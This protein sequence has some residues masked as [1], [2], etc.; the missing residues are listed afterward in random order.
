MMILILFRGS[1]WFVEVLVGV[2]GLLLDVCLGTPSSNYYAYSRIFNLCVG[3]LTVGCEFVGFP[4]DDAS[5]WCIGFVNLSFGKRLLLL[6][7]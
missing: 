4:L 1:S 2:P 6:T 5:F 3:I 7:Y